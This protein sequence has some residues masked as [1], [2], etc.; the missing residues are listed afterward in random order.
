MSVAENYVRLFYKGVGHLVPLSFVLNEHPGGAEYILQYANQDITSVFEDVGHSIDAH[1]F[2][3]TFEETPGDRQKQIYN[4]SKYKELLGDS[5][6]FTDE[7]IRLA[8][9]RRWRRRNVSVTMG[10]TLAA[11]AASIFF[12]SRLRQHS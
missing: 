11:M 1:A 5:L 10:T 7:R 2:L 12:L 9:V 3:K 6:N 4:E 8:E